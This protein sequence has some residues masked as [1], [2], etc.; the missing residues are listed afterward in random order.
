MLDEIENYTELFG[1]DLAS[2]DPDLAEIISL[3]QERQARRLIFIP[4]ESMCLLPVRQALASP[5]TNIYAEYRKGGRRRALGPA[6]SARGVQA[7]LRSAILQGH[8][9]R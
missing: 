9:V 8:R 1:R 4:S 5:F 7:L 3:E 2:V 6:L